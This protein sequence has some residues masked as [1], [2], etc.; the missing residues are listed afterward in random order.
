[1][2]NNIKRNLTIFN[3]DIVETS[4]LKSLIDD[5]PKAKHIQILHKC[6][7]G[8]YTNVDP[9]AALRK[10]SQRLQHSQKPLNA[11]KS[12]YL[13]HL[14]NKF[15]ITQLTDKIIDQQSK[16]PAEVLM[17]SV[18][19]LYYSYLKQQKNAFDKI[20]SIFKMNRQLEVLMIKTNIP[21]LKEIITLLIIDII[22]IYES[23]DI[24]E[25]Y[26]KRIRAMKQVRRFVD[27]KGYLQMNQELQ[28]K[29]KTL[30][31]SD[32]KQQKCIESKI[33]KTIPISQENETHQL[34]ISRKQLS[35]QVNE[36]TQFETYNSCQVYPQE[37]KMSL[38][39]GT[40]INQKG[41]VQSN[42]TRAS[43]IRD[44]FFV[45][46]QGPLSFLIPS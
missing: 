12:L 42:T 45:P 4:W 13:A 32:I 2:F 34:E 5:V 18:A 35:I 11:L 19:H 24:K 39:T 38:Q 29:L 37:R 44:N 14:L 46:K 40:I 17:A 9:K 20:D 7:S 28:N 41:I 30:N 6:L 33:C 21:I 10:I 31:F 22:T 23:I 15:L 26:E 8:E 25:D 16:D 27:L 1:M 43:S 36:S 3:K